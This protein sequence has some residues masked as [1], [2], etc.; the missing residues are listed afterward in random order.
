MAL[1]ISG[2]KQSWAKLFMNHK[3]CINNVFC[4]Y[5]D[6]IHPNFLHSML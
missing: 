3:G 1:L 4:N 2:F 5:L 6:I